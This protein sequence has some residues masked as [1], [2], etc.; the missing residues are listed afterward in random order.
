MLKC[1]A[2]YYK[3]KKNFLYYIHF[4]SKKNKRITMTSNMLET[5]FLLTILIA[6]IQGSHFL[7]GSIT[8]RIFNVSN[9]GTSVTII[10]TQNYQVKYNA[11]TCDSGSFA[12]QI[13]VP[14]LTGSLACSP[15]CPSGF[16]TISTSPYC[17]DVSVS[18]G[19][20]SGQRLD[21]VTIPVNSDFY[22]YYASTAW[23]SGVTGASGWSVSSHI[24]LVR[25]SDNNQFNNA[26]VANV[27]SPLNIQINQITNIPLSISDAD[28][29]IIRCRW[30]NAS[31]VVNEC[32]SVCSPSNLPPNTILYSNCTIEITG[33][34]NGAMYAISFM[35]NDFIFN[36]KTNKY[37]YYSYRQKILLIQRVHHR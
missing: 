30:A 12:N 37:E 36:I 3:K 33:L 4:N 35:V 29:D 10:I 11:G 32:G 24:N 21:T 7:G 22:V 17:T 14:G 16:G 19:I 27:I 1:S 25:R 6:P 20:A 18:N 9:S 31:G 13:V 23:Y 34:V 15:S 5:I 2:L 26:P 8:W 28:G